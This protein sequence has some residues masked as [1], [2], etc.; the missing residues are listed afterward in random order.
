MN[1]DDN[2]ARE[3]E[4]Q[5]GLEPY[6]SED[7]QQN[8]SRNN[9]HVSEDL[10]E[11]DAMKE[12][13][14]LEEDNE[15]GE[16]SQLI[17]DEA[18]TTLVTSRKKGINSISRP[19]KKVFSIPTNSFC[20]KLDKCLSSSEL[21][22]RN[23]RYYISSN[24][25]TIVVLEE[26]P[27]I[28][29]INVQSSFESEIENLRITGRLEEFGYTD[30]LKD[31]GQPYRFTLSFPYIVYIIQILPYPKSPSVKVS[32]FYRNAP[33]ISL[34]DSLFKCN[35]LNVDSRNVCCMGSDFEIPKL[36]DLNTKIN[37]ILDSFWNST[38][39]REIR[40]CYNSYEQNPHLSTFLHWQYYSSKDPMFI[41][42][43]ELISA[44]QTVASAI[45]AFDEDGGNK[46]LVDSY[47]S[48][49]DILF[50]DHFA[51]NETSSLY[52]VDQMPLTKD[53]I[54][55][56]S[57]EEIILHNEKV[58]IIDFLRDD[59]AFVKIRVETQKGDV[60]DV[61]VTPAV[62]KSLTSQLRDKKYV[63]SITV[64]DQE[65][66]PGKIIKFSGSCE[67]YTTVVR[68]ILKDRDGEFLTKCGRD[69][70]LLE[71]I[72]FEV[73]DEDQIK[74]RGMKLEKGKKYIILGSRAEHLPFFYKTETPTPK[75][76][77]GLDG[78]DDDGDPV[79][80]LFGD[81][82]LIEF[83][84]V[85]NYLIFAEED[86]ERPDVVRYGQRLLEGCSRIK[87]SGLFARNIKSLTS[88]VINKLSNEI[89]ARQE[90]LIPSYDFDVKFSVGDRVVTPD[91]TRPETISQIR[92]ITGFRS[93]T[94]LQ[95]IDI[96]TVGN[97]GQVP[98]ATKYLDFRNESQVNVG[99]VRKISE[100]FGGIKAGFKMIPKSR[101]IQ[102][103]MKK[104]CYE[105][106]GFITDTGNGIP[107]MLCSNLCTI[108]CTK[109]D[110]EKFDFFEPSSSKFKRL[111]VSQPALNSISFQPGDL[112]FS[113]RARTR[114]CDERVLMLLNKPGFGQTIPLLKPSN[115]NVC[116]CYRDVLNPIFFYGI[117]SPRI[118]M[119]PKA[120]T[121]SG[122]FDRVTPFPGFHNTIFD[123]S[124]KY[125]SGTKIY[126]RREEK[127][128]VSDLFS[129]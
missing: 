6:L 67:E 22:P 40:D 80:L 118:K 111:E 46:K 122:E 16:V 129:R 1:D 124:E 103:F 13:D 64:K 15:E 109:Q 114:C 79:C 57:G 128:N 117:P 90:L 47:K 55:L 51:F 11:R 2:V 23:V 116:K 7:I 107:L 120:F 3:D 106:T 110:L 69:F 32:V 27:C 93:T 91:W 33:L 50:D 85:N 54:M 43:E 59:K 48:I 56:D 119:D 5:A 42:S 71:N 12:E 37:I 26:E 18:V 73:F 112:I 53:G 102:N 92:T 36:A 14:E 8:D 9:L 30:F 4:M 113:N 75:I 68:K 65:V 96:I 121:E 88:Q 17:I 41:M 123:I 72:D 95:S 35:L 82:T 10:Q 62:I 60:I 29:S 104:D 63:Q 61:N 31:D 19:Y 66:K 125:H 77:N 115:T 25:G 99:S 52:S 28:R 87:G 58:F 24:R 45:A 89:I 83:D 21:L 108:W 38:F 49:V 126:I 76:Y 101:G 74:V 70:Y 105:V 44:D 100:E 98:S 94:D 39:N 127:N 84:E 97:Q 20:N 86:I 81:S 78:T 34:Q